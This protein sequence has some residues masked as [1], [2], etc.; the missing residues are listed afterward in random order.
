MKYDRHSE[1]LEIIQEKDIETQEELAQELRK[2]G[3]N[4]TQRASI[5]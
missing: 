1:I 2:R 4:V 5:G 3:F